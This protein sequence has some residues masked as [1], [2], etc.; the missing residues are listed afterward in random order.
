MDGSQYRTQKVCHGEKPRKDHMEEDDKKPGGLGEKA[1]ER[2]RERMRRESGL[3]RREQD[4][5][6]T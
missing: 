6:K 4:T 5:W 3:R 1:G 2:E